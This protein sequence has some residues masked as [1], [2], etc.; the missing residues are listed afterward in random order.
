L[1]GPDTEYGQVIVMGSRRWHYNNSSKEEIAEFRKRSRVDPS[2][3]HQV[4]Q[5]TKMPSKTKEIVVRLGEQAEMNTSIVEKV[6]EQLKALPGE[7][8]WRVL[9]VTR[10][11]SLSTS[12]G[13]SGKQLLRFAGA[14]LLGNVKLMREAIEQGCE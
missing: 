7:L 11:L 2:M 13:A 5:P 8:Q 9:E 14:V 10:A 3:L 12:R 4:S 1:G 6:V